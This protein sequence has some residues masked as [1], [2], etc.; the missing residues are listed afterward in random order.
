MRVAIVGGTGK[1]GRAL[2][3]RLRDAGDDVVIGSRDAERARATADELRVEGAANEDCVR[4]VELVVLAVDA[5][6]AL[7]T[8]RSLASAIGDTPVLSVA[9]TLKAQTPSL[10]EQIA[11]LLD[12]PVAAGF[13]TVA[14]YA[15]DREQ[16]TL[17]CGDDEHAKKLALEV[18][19]HAL[20]GRG[21]D[22]GPLAG[23]TALEALTG[24][25][26]KINRNYKA[27]AGIRVTGLP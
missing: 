10:A 11:E 17:V 8:A 9:S 15:F 18:A 16:D 5:K 25:L 7:D 12:G 22:A 23:A 26:L 14:A 21:V 3:E 27:H 2:A 4:G 24:V 13:H 19:D 6:A 20:D 1:F